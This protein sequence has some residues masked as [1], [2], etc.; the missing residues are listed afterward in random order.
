MAT[1]NHV[2][3]KVS[4]KP[5]G[6]QVAKRWCLWTLQYSISLLQALDSN[7]KEDQAPEIRQ[8]QGQMR[9]PIA[10][11]SPKYLR[12]AAQGD[13]TIEQKLQGWPTP[14]DSRS[15]GAQ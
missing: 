9:K 14:Q 3:R 10:L 7:S 13:E 1:D 15:L 5:D 8:V 12:Y 4:N 11:G 6:V 2:W